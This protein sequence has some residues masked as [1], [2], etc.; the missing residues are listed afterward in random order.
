MNRGA[1]AGRG[2]AT[3]LSMTSPQTF[4]ALLLLSF[5]GPE[6]PEDVRP[7]LENVTRGR[8][9]PPERLDEVGAHYK[10]FGGKSPLNDL[11][12]EII[13]HLKKAFAEA[14]IDLPI[15]FG[16]RNWHPFAEDTAERMVADGVTRCLV[17]ATSAWGGYSGCRQYHE[18][19]HR[20]REH[21]ADLP[22]APKPIDFVKIRQFFDHPLFIQAETEAVQEKLDL[23]EPEFGNLTRLVF[24]AHSIPTAADESSGVPAD[25][26]LYSTQIAQAC[27]LV[28]EGVKVADYDLVWNSRSGSPH[29]PWLEPDVVDHVTDLHDRGFRAC[30]V[31]PIGFVSDHIEVV[32][33]LDSELKREAAEYG[34]HIER[35]R[36][37][38]PTQK[39]TDMVVELVREH[40]DG[41]PPRGLGTVPV[42]GCTRNGAPCEEGCCLPAAR[43]AR[44]PA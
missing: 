31:V 26:P 40:L 25:G 28:A 1:G 39:F 24:T 22:G 30:V 11:N 41:L 16:N 10:H 2:E 43:P 21:I 5:G 35:A 44:R 15:Y 14:K 20:M 23:I 42:K 13:E 9:I 7:F 4:D 27:R 33:D 12:L 17:L 18:D 19:I 34:M 3:M 38:G 37:V 32:W 6:G 36:T 8:G 29:T